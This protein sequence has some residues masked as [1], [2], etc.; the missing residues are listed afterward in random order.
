M[1]RPIRVLE[2]RCADGPG[3]GPEKTIIHGAARADGERLAITVCYIREKDDTDPTIRER[4]AVCGIDLH[5]VVQ[6]HAFD[7]SVYH[8]V[9]KLCRSREIEIVHAH[10]YKT[11]LLAW[12]LAR[13]E[14]LTPL[15]TAHGWT[16]HS[17]RERRMLYPADKYL[18]SRYP[19]VLAVSSEIAREL[20]R[21]GTSP[22]TVRVLLNGIDHQH[23][24]CDHDRVQE[25][26]R[27]LGIPPEVFVIG[28][29]GRIE[30]QKRFDLLIQAFAAVRR[31]HP[32]AM[33]LIAGSGSLLGN[34]KKL[35]SDL[36]LGRACRFLGHFEAIMDFYHSLDLFVQSSDYEGTPNVVLEAMAMEV[37][38]IATAV[39]GTAELLHDGIHGW[40]IP[41][42][43]ATRLASAISDA[44]GQRG[45]LAARAREARR[46]VE[47]DLSFDQRCQSLAEIYQEVRIR[48]TS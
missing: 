25:C 18:L 45:G 30:S 39:G 20:I 29:V 23:F 28:S 8:K 19:M 48:K 37:P 43:D 42:G 32:D 12:A 31:S 17:L 33:L 47:T 36:G 27:L 16:G 35:A 3:G 46:R 10:D 1:N 11:D 22:G 38:V 14:G 4:A 21:S 41:P 24:R 34:C 5:E 40:L 13:L 9:R 7:L 6:R 44:V 15:A 2:L 26:R